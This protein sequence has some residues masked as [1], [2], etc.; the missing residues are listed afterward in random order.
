MHPPPAYIG[1]KRVSDSSAEQ[2]RRQWYQQLLIDEAAASAGMGY[3][4]LGVNALFPSLFTYIGQLKKLV[5][6]TVTDVEI[7]N[8]C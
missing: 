1:V 5:G 3:Y 7:D 4:A 2:Q 8:V 6:C